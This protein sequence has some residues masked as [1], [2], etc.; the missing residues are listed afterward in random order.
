MADRAAGEG[1]VGVCEDGDDADAVDAIDM[2]HDLS[3]VSFS[4]QVASVKGV[5]VAWSDPNSHP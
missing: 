2:R 5:P 4:L 1:E 3:C